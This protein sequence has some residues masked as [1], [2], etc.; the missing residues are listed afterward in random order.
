MT[1]VFYS[2]LDVN[3]VDMPFLRTR[4]L[5]VVTLF[6][7]K[8]LS[9]PLNFFPSFARIRASSSSR[10]LSL[11]RSGRRGKLLDALEAIPVFIICSFLSPMIWSTVTFGVGIWTSSNCNGEGCC[12]LGTINFRGESPEKGDSGYSG[13]S[14]VPEMELFDWTTQTPSLDCVFSSYYSL[15]IFSFALATGVAWGQDYVSNTLL[16]PSSEVKRPQRDQCRWDPF[17]LLWMREMKDLWRL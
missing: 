4:K 3:D 10:C 8:H 1:N 2:K 9:S 13:L 14:R 12:D 15:I 5:R 7:R 11:S 6:R 16:I 17:I